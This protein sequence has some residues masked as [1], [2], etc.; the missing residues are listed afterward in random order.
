MS[1]RAPRC[2]LEN[3]YLCAYG[4]AAISAAVFPFLIPVS[5]VTH[6]KASVPICRTWLLPL[7]PPWTASAAEGVTRRTGIPHIW[8]PI[9]FPMRPC[10]TKSRWVC[11]QLCARGTLMYTTTTQPAL[12]PLN[13]HSCSTDPQSARRPPNLA[14]NAQEQERMVFGHSQGYGFSCYQQPCA[15]PCPARPYPVPTG[16]S[17]QGGGGTLPCP[18]AQAGPG[19]PTLVHWLPLSAVGAG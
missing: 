5:T 11:S 18:N 7:A 12:G 14:E 16:K 4:S 2:N 17:C 19:W 8:H 10:L 13:D 9:T 1:I 6:P 3:R 15:V